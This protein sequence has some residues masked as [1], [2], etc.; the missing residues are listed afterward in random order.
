MAEIPVDH[1]IGRAVVIDIS[2]KAAA[3]PDYTLKPED[4]TA[5]EAE[6]GIVPAGAIVLLRTG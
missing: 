6:H 5:W 3:D 1:L 2:T 4:V